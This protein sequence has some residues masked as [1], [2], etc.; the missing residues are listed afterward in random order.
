MASQAVPHGASH[1]E[2]QLVCFGDGGNKQHLRLEFENYRLLSSRHVFLDI[3]AQ[4]FSIG[5]LEVIL[6]DAEARFKF[7][8]GESHG[9]LSLV[10]GWGTEVGVVLQCT[11]CGEFYAGGSTVW[12]SLGRSAD[13]NGVVVPIDCRCLAF[14]AHLRV[15]SGESSEERS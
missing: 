1:V 2:N 9:V 10:V 13:I 3:F 14:S 15:L 8:W 11:S 12:R 5:D 7:W 6:G 4:Y